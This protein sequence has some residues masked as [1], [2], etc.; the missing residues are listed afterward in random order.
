MAIIE[1]IPCTKRFMAD[2]ECFIVSLLGFSIAVEAYVEG[3]AAPYP[4]DD[5]IILSCS[6]DGGRWVVYPHD[7]LALL[8]RNLKPQWIH[9]YKEKCDEN[10]YLHKNNEK[11]NLGAISS[12]M[13]TLMQSLSIN[14]YERYKSEVINRYGNFNR[15]EWP[16]VWKFAKVVRDAMSHNYRINFSE[17][18]SKEFKVEWRNLNYSSKNNGQEIIFK[19]MWP[20]DFFDLIIEMD[21]YLPAECTSE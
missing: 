3:K 6:T 19:D 7:T 17:H 15:D 18:K 4:P 12:L 1:F 13:D 9:M 10:E 11:T 21:S 8:S 16:E 5:T 20:G 2:F 14:Y